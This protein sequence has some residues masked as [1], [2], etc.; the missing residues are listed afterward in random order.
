MKLSSNLPRLLVEILLVI[1]GTEALVMWLL[2]EVAPGAT[3]LTENIIDVSALL[4]LSAPA[5]F[6]R[7]RAHW[8]NR[9]DIRRNVDVGGAGMNRRRA[10]VLA[11]AAQV[12][13]LSG[14]AAVVWWQT[15]NLDNQAQVQ[16]STEVDHLERDILRRLTSAQ[17]GLGGLRGTYAASK[18]V[19]RSEFRAYV[20]SRDMDREFPGIRGFGF[21]E[22]VPRQDLDRFVA[23]V[24]A[25][26]AP[27]FNV[28]TTGSAP[29]LWVIRFI[30]PLAKNIAAWGLDVGQDPVR[31]EAAERAA[32]TGKTAL[33]G[34]ITLVQDGAKTPGF[35]LY[36]P[37]YRA[38]ARPTTPEQRR[39]ALIGLSY[40]PIV[41]SEL[42]RGVSETIPTSLA[43][44]LFQGGEV[45]EDQW[46]Y[47]SSGKYTGAGDRSAKFAIQRIGNVAGVQF[48][49]HVHSTPA[50]EAAQD[51]SSLTLAALLGIAASTLITLA[52]WLLATGQARARQLAKSMT[53]DLDRMARVVQHTNN[54]VA[55][56]DA[57]EKITWIN[58]GFTRLTGY[59]Q[60]EALGK[61]PG[62][63][64]SSGK[65]SLDVIQTLRHAVSQGEACRVEVLNRAKDGRE[66][67]ADTEI[68]PL[69]D[70]AGVLTGFM[71]IGTDITPAK[72]S[73]QRLEAAIREA[74]ALLSTV[75]MHA[76]VSITDGDGTIIEVNDAY[77]A[78]SGYSR[79]ELIGQNHRTGNSGV[80]PPEFWAEFWSAIGAGQSWRG[81]V[82]NRSKDGGLY[83]VDCMIAP[84]IGND[85]K[86]EKYVSIRTDITARVRDQQKIT[87]L[88]NRMTLAT[89]GSSDGLWDWMDLTQAEQWWSPRYHA[90]L[91]YEPHELP[92]SIESQ[93]AI[94]HPDFRE[95][96][97]RA[98]KAALG[99]GVD[100]DVELQ[101]QTKDAGYRW[102]RL[103]G[104]VYFDANGKAQR[105]AGSAQDIHERKLAQ[106]SVA[107]SNRRFALAAD[108]AGIGV[109]EW[110]LQA[111]VVAWDAQ[112][113]A[114]YQHDPH[115]GIS[116]LKIVLEALHA[117]DKARFEAAMQQSLL[118][119]V[120]F[121]GDYRILWP[122][123]E[124]RHIRSGARAERDS[125]GQVIRLT[126][127]NF[128]ITEVKRVQEA[129][130]ES[131]A[132]LDRA[133]HIAGVGGW[134]VDLRTGEAHW[135]NETR[136]IHEVD[137]DF[138][139]QLDQAIQ[140][141][142]P[143]AR[144]VIEAAVQHAVAT[145]EGW[146]LELPLLTAKGNAIWVRSVGEVEYEGTTPVVLVGAFQDITERRLREQELHLLESCITRISDGVLITTAKALSEPGP[147]IVFVNPALERISG[148]SADELLGRTPRILQGPDSDRHALDRIRSALERGE[149]VTEELLNYN[150]DGVPYW[151][152]VTISP[153]LSPAGELTHFVA[154]ERD[155]TERRKKD[156]ELREAL[157][158]A[159]SAAQEL[160][161]SQ[162]LLTSSIQAL[163]DAF[164]LYD[165]EDRLVLCNQRYLEF[166][167]ESA[168]MLQPGNRFE[169]IIRYGAEQGQ[170]QEAI[171]REEEW[172]QERLA[173][174]RLPHSSVQQ[175]LST[176]RILRVVERRTDAG[177][178]VGFR[179]DITDLVQATEAAEE[180][181]RSK[182][183]FLANM[184]HEIRTPMNAILGMLKLLQ[185]TELSVR[186]D[187]YAGKAEAAARSLLGL[188]NDILDFS[189]V[190]AGKMTLDPRPFRFDKL[191]RDLSVIFSNSVG[192]K[193]IEILFDIDPALPEAAVCDDMR[194][195]QVLINLGGNAIKFTSQGEVIVRLRVVEKT[196]NDVVVE[197]SVK[198]S[199]IGIAPE[200]QQHIFS[201]FSQAEAN[202]TRRFGGTGLGLAISNRLTALL[203]GTLQ[204]ES[205]LGKGSTFHFQIR[206]PI[207]DAS[208]LAPSSATATAAAATQVAPKAA[209]TKRVLVVDDNEVARE[210]TVNLAQS[211]GWQVDAADSGPEA[212]RMVQSCAESGKQYDAIFVDW[213]MPGMD[214][215]EASREIRSVNPIPAPGTGAAAQLL[216]VMVTGH[217][218]EMLAERS[219]PE[220]AM[221]DG[222]LVKPVTASMLRDAVHEA[223]AANTTAATGS[224]PVKAQA[225]VKPKRLLGMRILVVEDNKINQMVAK[226][227]LSAE[228]ADITLADDGELGV[229]AAS[230]TQPPFDAV[231]MDVQ[232]PVMD[233]YTATRTLRAMP[234]FEDLPI[235]AMTA[236]AMASD[237]AA[238]L[239][240]GMNDHVG[241]PFELDH[242]VA[243]LL[244]LGRPA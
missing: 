90:M 99:G 25:D 19:N 20:E 135:S 165:A 209:Q 111:K 171:G 33:S 234:G 26:E 32:N 129:L 27:D 240:A 167:P 137:D 101:L 3:G 5:I 122:N 233:G 204:L 93:R 191:L 230:T 34:K 235:I 56:S 239:A 146:D 92:P 24:R 130:A 132:F 232:M 86:V 201:G 98:L 133:G 174:H 143:E 9:S 89:E 79:E 115:S 217:G 188:L 128:D 73:Q 149:A 96:S 148:Y 178:T 114:I 68:Q 36:D 142:A 112:M 213:K 88:S 107:E 199:G 183:Q 126:G 205:A 53:A 106:A 186:Q 102:F 125:G 87:D 72:E 10:I 176:G 61:S 161:R 94:C 2:P 28:K 184:S 43:F 202:T 157:D 40:A 104:K 168:A 30:E 197:F 22:Y 29:D 185:N 50:Y 84:F 224:D 42:L 105:M 194:L 7:I 91:G 203:G 211:L 243:T 190:E 38:D 48:T 227:V 215:W 152:A 244:R 17:Y 182:S 162:N 187:D 138:V 210:V 156:Q 14:T 51:R 218:R 123:G 97:K 54:A 241:K 74:T 159:E 175:R 206:M 116:P 64:L 222:F 71:E 223:T 78:I 18:E 238:C 21:I 35:L 55:I 13:G 170:Y 198:D 180:A 208:L 147:E 139:P 83:W 192:A 4:M 225:P 66:Y 160:S 95:E 52:V 60:D 226:G 75:E 45:R 15:S 62:E 195:Q 219:A 1:A 220:Q 8:L 193:D 81:D 70:A 228:G 154:V 46:I 118:Q 236:N 145:G 59:T 189:K 200:N 77:C 12:V 44:D 163:D 11:V 49:L 172:V 119:G 58:P 207:A 214:G 179:V 39:A 134:R 117:D 127:V 65:A 177:Y 31:R 23:A 57:N 173:K 110:D 153:V 120:E 166:Y 85:G 69:R 80:H 155:V 131:T 169:D 229:A 113:Y 47:G 151:I 6:W 141:Y 242:L 231:L 124:V 164:V 158:S 108:S 221:L 150:K 237:R 109:W 196:S 144:P 100:Y 63:L 140:F 37:I 67:W 76:I 216:I 82:C 41:A 16:F 181:S 121:G 103:H 212:I 136:R